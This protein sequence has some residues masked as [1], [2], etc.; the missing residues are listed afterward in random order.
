MASHG[1]EGIRLRD[2]VHQAAK[3][4]HHHHIAKR[5]HMQQ[6]RPGYIAFLET[7]DPPRQV[8]AGEIDQP[9][10]RYPP[11]CEQ[12]VEN[13]KAIEK[14]GER[15]GLRFALTLAEDE[16]DDEQQLPGQRIE[17]PAARHRIIRHIDGK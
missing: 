9:V 7:P 6:A 15:H 16:A 8:D 10:E 3:R 4:R 11:I 17:E 14:P 5:Q 13:A 1:G 2:Q 12:Q